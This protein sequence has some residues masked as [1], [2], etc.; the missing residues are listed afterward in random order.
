MPANE[1][2]DP[3]PEHPVTDWSLMNVIS[4]KG[5]HPQDKPIPL[6]L[7]KPEDKAMIKNITRNYFNDSQIYQP[8]YLAI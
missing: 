6:T 2:E 3:S 5:L 4:Q 7:L 8:Y 1:P